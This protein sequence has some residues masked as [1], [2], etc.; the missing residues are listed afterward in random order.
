MVLLSKYR[1]W[2]LITS[3][4]LVLL[5][6]GAYVPATLAESDVL[7]LKEGSQG[8]LIGV[9][10]E[11]VHIDK[12]QKLKQVTVSIPKATGPIEEVVVT[13]PRLDSP[14]LDKPVFQLKPYTFIKDYDNDRYG[15]IIYI[16]ENNR[17]PFR[18]YF[19]GE[20]QE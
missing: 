19:N 18:L 2:E 10:V 16:G 20:P 4:V 11:D 7:E 9:R 12:D 14:G 8:N 6:T 17:L 1:A 13:A 3:L 5:F 15:L